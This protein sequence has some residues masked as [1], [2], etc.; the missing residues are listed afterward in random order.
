MQRL[1]KLA[2]AF[3][4]DNATEATLAVYA[5]E[6]S[7]MD[8]DAVCAAL[9]TLIR[10]ARRL[11]ALA[12]IIEEYHQE[13][14]RQWEQMKRESTAVALPIGRSPMPESLKEQLREL[15]GAFD[16]RAAEMDQT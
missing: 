16:Q 7:H 9:D 3:P 14:E 5:E 11:P 6:L 12:D 15:H 4:R 8:E 1:T 13:R 10:S 2:A